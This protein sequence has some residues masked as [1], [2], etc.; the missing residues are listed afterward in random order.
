L[1]EQGDGEHARRHGA[2]DASAPPEPGLR[3]R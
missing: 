3:A 2:R 1:R